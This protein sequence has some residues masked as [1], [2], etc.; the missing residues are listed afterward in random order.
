MS[1]QEGLFSKENIS[2][3]LHHSDVQK[4]DLDDELTDPFII[5]TPGNNSQIHTAQAFHALGD[6]RFIN[7]SQNVSQGISILRDITFYTQHNPCLLRQ[8]KVV[9]V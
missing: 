4:D 5:P 9:K 7:H 1:I 6:R 8:L 2:A 3:A